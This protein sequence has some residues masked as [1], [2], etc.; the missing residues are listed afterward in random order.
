MATTRN[1]AEGL[2]PAWIAP[3]F[4]WPLHKAIGKFKK[5]LALC[6]GND[7]RG[8]LSKMVSAITRI[9]L[10]PA[11]D[12]TNGFERAMEFHNRVDSARVWIAIDCENTANR[13]S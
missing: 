2:R 12:A 10:Q 5:N 4:L 9:Y 1:L 13:K 11:F 8:I 7:R 6:A 3:G